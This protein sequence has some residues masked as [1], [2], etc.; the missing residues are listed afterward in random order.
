V[1]AEEL[2]EVSCKYREAFRQ[3]QFLEFHLGAAEGRA[4][5]RRLHPEE[6]FGLLGVEGHGSVFIPQQTLVFGT[7]LL[8]PQAPDNALWGGWVET[9]RDRIRRLGEQRVASLGMEEDSFFFN[10]ARRASR[11]A[12]AALLASGEKRLRRLRTRAPFSRRQIGDEADQLK[13][14]SQTRDVA[15][16]VPAV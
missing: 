6:R 7:E 14:T 5:G 15:D 10:S 12:D 2:L 4:V 11:G 3:A 13:I 8:T 1:K 16:I 9:L